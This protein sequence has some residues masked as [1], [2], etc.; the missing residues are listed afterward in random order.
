MLWWSTYI[1]TKIHDVGYEILSHG[2]S[3]RRLTQMSCPTLLLSLA[4][5]PLPSQNPTTRR[6]HLVNQAPT[7]ECIAKTKWLFRA[8]KNL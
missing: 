1:T 3:R 5:R 6:E 7:F 2:D 4:L 8:L